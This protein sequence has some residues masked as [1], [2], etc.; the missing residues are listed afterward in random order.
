[1]REGFY[2]CIVMLTRLIQAS[3]RQDATREQAEWLAFSYIGRVTA[4]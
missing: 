3:F 1:M 2:K 4:W